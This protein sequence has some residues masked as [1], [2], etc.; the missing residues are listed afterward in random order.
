MA[1]S[2]PVSPALA[3][4]AEVN[5]TVGGRSSSVIVAVWTVVAPRVAFVGAPR[6]RT[7]VSSV[8]SRV[9]VAIV[10][11]ASAVVAPAGMSSGEAVTE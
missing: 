10:M 6:V 5:W 1:V 11:T 2:V 4:A 7:T 8:S 9:S 3:W